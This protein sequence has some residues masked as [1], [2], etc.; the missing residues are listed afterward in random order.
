VKRLRPPTWSAGPRAPETSQGL[1]TPRSTCGPGAQRPEAAK[2][3]Q[4]WAPSVPGFRI[5][6]CADASSNFP[7]S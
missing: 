1:V 7:T 3:L 2:R 5:L 6:G 4:G